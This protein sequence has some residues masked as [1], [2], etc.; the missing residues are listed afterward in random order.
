M[1]NVSVGSTLRR[2]FEPPQLVN[3]NPAGGLP[4][5]SDVWIECGGQEAVSFLRSPNNIA[6]EL[7]M[8][9]G[10]RCDWLAVRMV[11]FTAF[12]ISCRFNSD[13]AK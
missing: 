2:V 9:F 11:S 6:R 3:S 7:S 10:R 13:I 4:P 1:D 12:L 5:A 8:S